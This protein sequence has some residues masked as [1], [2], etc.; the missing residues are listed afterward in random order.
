MTRSLAEANREISRVRGLPYGAARTQ[1]AEQ[2]A[3]LVEAEGPDQARAYALLVL[4]E[5]YV[6]AGEVDR[7][8][9]PF[10]QAVRWYDEHPEHLDETDVHQLFWSFKW[11]VG[12]LSDFPDVPAAQIEATLADM[13]RRYA[14]AGLGHDAVAY[15]KFCWARKRGAPDVD[16]LYEQWVRTPRDDFSQCEVCDPGD[17]ATYLVERGDVEDAARLIEQ[18]LAEGG[19]CATEPA[20][21]LARLATLHLE[22]GR[23]QEAAATHRRAVAALADSESD[24]AGAR[25]ARFVLLARGGQ[26]RRAL[27]ALASD[28]RLLQRADTPDDTFWFLADVVAGTSALLP[29][30]ATLPVELDGVPVRDV[31]GL[32]DWA[33]SRAAALARAFDARNGTDRYARSLADARATRPTVARLDLDVIPATGPDAPPAGGTV[34]SAVADDVAAGESAFAR[35]ERLTE[36]GDVVAA[37]A[38]WLEAAREAEAAGRLADAGLALAEAARCAQEASDDDG[39]AATYPGAVARM[40]AGGTPV[41]DVV[42]VVV[43]WAPAAVVTGTGAA[44]V[45]VV[46]GLLGELA[47]VP[48]DADA[49]VDPVAQAAG[50]ELDERLSYARRRARADLHDTA[51][52]VLASLGGDHLPDAARRAARAAEGYAGVDAVA[53]AAHAFWLAGRLHAG[54]GA[55]DEAVWNLESAVEGFAMVRQHDHRG[56]VVSAL[57][58][59]LRGAGRDER[60]DEVLRSLTR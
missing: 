39:A 56:E 57:V 48:A 23:A 49:P 55:V 43:A 30:H 60:A 31:T 27:R 13:E 1:A 35:A 5:S 20:D 19:T 42:P 58:D 21:M 41:P 29:D 52:R 32:R 17:R 33:D 18:T 9:L 12:H 38:A 40:R 7:A 37:A 14:V 6:W 47:D 50:A 34:A 25:G 16:E 4:V 51:A 45:D 53:D 10:T 3:R 59:V 44:V 36:A 11:M 26:P 15:E 24:M 54:L 46:D 28:A 22:A 2:Q 8:Y